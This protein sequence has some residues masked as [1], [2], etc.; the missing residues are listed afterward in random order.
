M[1]K[2]ADMD[3]AGII[4]VALSCIAKALTG[5]AS[6]QNIDAPTRFDFQFAWRNPNEASSPIRCAGKIV[7]VVIDG[8]LINV[9]K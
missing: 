7:R 3:V 4:R 1:S 9:S 5:R 8:E 6:Q 2:N